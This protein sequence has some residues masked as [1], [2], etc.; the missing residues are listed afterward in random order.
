MPSTTKKSTSSSL[1]SFTNTRAAKK[2]QARFRQKK[3]N[4]TR[5]NAAKKLQARFRQKKANVTRTNAAKKLQRTYK[6]TKSH[7][8]CG[9]CLTYYNDSAFTRLSCGHKFHRNCIKRWLSKKNSCPNCRNTFE[10]SEFR[11]LVG[12][13]RRAAAERTNAEEM[14]MLV[15][16]NALAVSPAASSTTSRAI[17][18]ATARATRS[19]DEI[20][21]ADLMTRTRA[22]QTLIHMSIDRTNEANQVIAEGDIRFGNRLATEA[23]S[24]AVAALQEAQAIPESANTLVAQA[25]AALA[26]A[27]AA[28]ARAEA[29]R[30]ARVASESK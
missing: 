26:Q 16:A 25:E 1:K 10:E 14:R 7:G 5:T 15:A 17:A 3:A 22:A 27:E 2:I 23:Y 29:A 13:S 11:Q 18:R 24:I 28:V 21:R 20:A 4:E 9:I 30:A 12:M 6:A 19:V 8:S